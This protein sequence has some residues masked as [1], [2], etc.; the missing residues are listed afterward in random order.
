MKKTRLLV[1]SLMGLCLAACG[2]PAS[3]TGPSATS[4]ASSNVGPS[5][6]SSLFHTVTFN[7]NGGDAIA[8]QRVE[9]GSK[10]TKPTDPTRLGY[11]FLGW[12]CDG[13]LWSFDNSV[14]TQDITLIANWKLI[15]YQITYVLNGGT[16][17]YSNPTSYTVEDPITFADPT[18]DGF[19]FAG[20]YDEDNNKVLGIK[21]HT[22][23]R[24]LTLT[25][26]WSEE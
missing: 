21:Q 7:V 8:S 23:A 14:V 16:N 25:A 5:A 9:H 4:S 6:T 18:K 19:I 17:A 20:W 11:E 3:S 26:S 13:Q 24:D 12:I 2:H 10:A 22:I 15:S 1:I